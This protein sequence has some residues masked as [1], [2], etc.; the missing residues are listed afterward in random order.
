M[1]GLLRFLK[2]GV[3]VP[4]GLTPVRGF[5]PARY[6]GQWHEVARLDH[7]FERGLTQATAEYS[8]RTD[9]S[10]DVL[11]RGFDPGKGRWKEA[12][13]VA[14]FCGSPDV[15]SLKVSFFRPFWGAYHIIALDKERYWYSMVAGP[16]RSYPKNGDGD[17]RKKA[18]EAQNQKVRIKKHPVLSSPW[19]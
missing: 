7:W 16:N 1:L 5:E 11:N 8:L 12:R 6:L 19:G 18:Q 3:P 10:L 14:R 2:G 15:G 9:G 13:G 4:E 17:S